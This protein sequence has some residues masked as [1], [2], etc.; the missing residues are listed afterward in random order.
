MDCL[1]TIAIPTYNRKGL[2]K[3]ALESIL[4]QNS[5]E[6]EILVSDNASTDRTDLYMRDLCDSY[7]DIRY[8]RNAENIDAPRNFLQCYRESKGKFVLLLGSDDLMLPGAVAELVV[9]IKQYSDLDACFFNHT[10][11]DGDFIDVEHCWAR[12][13]NEKKENYVTQDKEMFLKAMRERCTFM[14]CFFLKRQN[15]LEALER[16][17]ENLPFFMST[18]FTQTCLFFA[19]TSDKYANLG[20]VY[21]PCVANDQ[22][23]GNVRLSSFHVYGL[24]LY[25]LLCVIAPKFGYDG[26][27]TAEIYKDFAGRRFARMVAVAKS[28]KKENWKA[29]FWEKCYPY[30]KKYPV[31]RFKCLIAYY[32]PSIVTRLLRKI[33]NIIKEF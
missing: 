27:V 2:L 30:I 25:N 19:S 18:R 12:H 28:E 7:K 9:F 32:A 29:D 3:R 6:I 33:N 8:I 16:E 10:Y 4:E 23:P 5:P 11:F 17:K 15:V 20:V 22:T 14:S 1:L 31:V 24:G 21:H 26:G 13:F